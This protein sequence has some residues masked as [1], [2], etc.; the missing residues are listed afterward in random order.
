[1]SELEDRQQA[2][3]E[4]FLIFEDWTSRYQMLI[5]M[6]KEL[7][8]DSQYQTNDYKVRGCQSQVWLHSEVKDNRIYFTGISDSTIVSG[9]IAVLIKIFSGQTPQDILA[10]P[11]LFIEKMG[12]EK[13]LSPTRRNG[14]FHMLVS[15]KHQAHLALE[16]IDD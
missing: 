7:S 8:F 10:A 1:M 3:V 15:I 5:S 9:L 2:M 14:L 4:D 13:H 12:L 16:K 6:G 11:I